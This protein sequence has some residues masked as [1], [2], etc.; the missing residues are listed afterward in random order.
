M[1]NTSRKLA[2][3]VFADI[4]GYTAMMQ[5]DESQALKKL[6]I[7]EKAIHNWTNANHG[8]V[9]QFYG[10]GCLLVFDN[11]NDAIA[12]T[13]AM[14]LHFMEPEKDVAVRF[15]IHAGEVVYRD[16]NVFSD[17]VNLASRVESM[18]IPGSILLSKAVQLQIK[19]NKEYHLHSLGSFDFKNVDEPM[20]VFALSN[21]GLKIPKREELKGKFKPKQK[22]SNTTLLKPIFWIALLL[23]GIWAIWQWTS[24][25]GDKTSISSNAP[26]TA[27]AI[28]PFSNIS[29]NEGLQYVSDGIAENLINNVS[30]QSTTKIISRHST[31]ALRDSIHNMSYIQRLLNVEAILVGSV[32]EVQDELVV[33]TELIGTGNQERI[34]GKKVR[35]T[36]KELGI[37][38]QQLSQSILEILDKEE[39]STDEKNEVIID[40][41]AYQHYMQ[42]RFMSFGTSQEEIDLSVDHFYKAIEIE[43]EFA[44][45][46]AALANQKFAQARFSNTSR[47]EMIREAKL[48]INNARRIDPDLPEAHLAEANIQFYCDFD[49]DGAE[50]SFRKALTEDPNNALI[51]ADFAFFQCAM[52]NY[53]EAVQ[54]A[55]KAIQLDPVS[56][57]SMHIIAW[58]NLYSNPELSVE[59]FQRMTELHP[60][61][62]WGHMKK[63]MAQVL[64]DDCTSALKTFEGVES[65][66]GEWGGDLLEVYLSILYKKCGAEKKSKEKVQFI[67][68]HFQKSGGPDPLHLAVLY[69]GTGNM[70]QMITYAEQCIKE[71]SINVAVMQLP[72]DL[73]FFYNDAMADPRYRALLKTVGLPNN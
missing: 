21:T 11:A 6:G 20:E 50:R 4:A 23:V 35:G 58:A 60:Q 24:A 65:R 48:A 45:A 28:F 31:F 44:L 66:T 59:Q 72:K 3:I 8:E 41:E 73:D 56:I 46:Y 32:D 7:F 22:S 40:P 27:L 47:Q 51:Y 34:W 19:N 5:Q 29:G 52:N 49:W 55:E 17:S 16:G 9:V 62:I 25:G 36:K 33:T 54:L 12:A 2:A 57:S 63:G 69:G 70:D 43:P 71:Q 18:G 38:E 42:G 61:W 30:N 10:D 15:G 67:L 26:L 37:I 68:D 1:S 53:E 39:K 13:L 14:Q 64:V